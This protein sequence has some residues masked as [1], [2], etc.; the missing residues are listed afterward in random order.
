MHWTE[1]RDRRWRIVAFA[2]AVFAFLY[3][4]VR[5][6]GAPQADFPVHYAFAQRFVRGEFLYEGGLN[7]PYAPF[8]AMFNAPLT[9]LPLHT[10]QI[11]LYPISVV[12]IVGLL[13]VLHALLPAALRPGSTAGFWASAVAVALAARFLVRDLADCGL[14]TGLALLAWFSIWCWRSRRDWTGGFSLGL[15]IALKWT[16]ALFLAWFIWKRQWRFACIT[17]LATALFTLA[18]ILRSGPSQFARE[19]STW[20]RAILAGV[21]ETDPSRGILGEDNFKNI[22]LRP[23]LARFLMRFPPG[24]AGRV[25][26]PWAIDFLDLTPAAA[27]LVTKA[28]SAA[29]L[30]AAAWLTRKPLR[31]RDDP[32]V[33]WECAMVALLSLLLSPITWRAHCV[34]VLPA[35][36]LL[37]RLAFIVRLP[38]RVGIPLAFYILFGPIL[39]RDLLGRD[40]SFLLDSYRVLTWAIAAL[41]LATV[42]AMKLDRARV[43]AA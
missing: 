42:L 2:A 7:T 16:P 10:A 32:Q 37:S 22:S 43:T 8:W 36:L 20:S 9:L 6:I 25:E 28:V 41:L 19:M 24:H 40:L 1:S 14:N 11:A 33:V 31:G 12:W 17:L 5:I 26:H 15:A 18:P 4:W 23:A 30:L 34:G 21:S 29:I 3:Q 39:S 27:S 38:L 35:C 13:R